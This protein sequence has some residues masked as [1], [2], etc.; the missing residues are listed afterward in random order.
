MVSHITRQNIHLGR[1]PEY[2]APTGRV[3]GGVSPENECAAWVSCI[4]V[5]ADK[6]AISD[7]CSAMVTYLTDHSPDITLQ[8]ARDFAP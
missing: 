6:S 4:A 5:E 2:V 3:L 7:F 8:H 1:R